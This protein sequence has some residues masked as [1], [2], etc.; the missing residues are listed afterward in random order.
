VDL[1]R[2][3]QMVDVAGHSLNT[4]QLQHLLLNHVLLTG[5]LFTLALRPSSLRAF[6]GPHTGGGVP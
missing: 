3:I 6:F 5:V 1:L 4:L 2:S